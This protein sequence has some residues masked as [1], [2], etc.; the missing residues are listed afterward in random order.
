MSEPTPQGP[1]GRR[2][3]PRSTDWRNALNVY[4]AGRS[5]ALT[6]EE[7]RGIA[8]AAVPP[9]QPATAPARASAT[10]PEPSAVAEPK[11]GVPIPDVLAYHRNAST[12][13]NRLPEGSARDVARD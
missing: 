10:D 9:P 11:F 5:R 12:W 13:R 8:S 7:K 2:P 6:F 1:F 4:V 3:L